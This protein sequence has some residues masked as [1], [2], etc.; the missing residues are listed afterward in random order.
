MPRNGMVKTNMENAEEMRKYRIKLIRDAVAWK[1][2]D[3][4]ANVSMF[5]AW[6]ILDAGCK[7]SEAMSDYGVLEKITREHIEKYNWDLM[8]NDGSRNPFLLYEALGA[9][10][11]NINDAEES[12]NHDDIF[13]CSQ[14]ELEEMAGD[15]WKFIWDKGMG[16][17]YSFWDPHNIDVDVIQNAIAKAGD[18]AAY[19]MRMSKIFAEEYG[20]PAFCAPY[21]SP[22]PVIENIFWNIRGIK[23]MSIDMRRNT[24]GFDALIDSLNEK[25]FDPAFKAFE[26]LPDGT[27][28]DACFESGTTFLCQNT[29]NMKQWEKYY[30][31]YVKKTLDTCVRKNY[32]YSIFPEGQVLRFADYF[33]DYPKGLLNFM[34]ENDD[35][36]EFR[37]TMPNCAIM[38]GMD[39]LLLDSG[40]AG[41]CV[42]LAKKLIDELG[43]E[44]GYIMTQTKLGTF[45]NDGNPVNVKAVCDFVRDYRF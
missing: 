42:D 34:L 11:Y 20:I 13:Y 24:A 8:V 39:T 40:T 29:L 7:L 27:F 5:Q 2:P 15:F 26:N 16:R 28:A 25:F 41:E 19:Q 35:V 30:W 14:D 21:F 23:G 37:K 12:I 32:T 31:P 22:Q 36:F 6:Q 38:G 9:E 17:K 43:T 1:K 44:G 18:H 4:I 3:R 33:N 10:T 45:R